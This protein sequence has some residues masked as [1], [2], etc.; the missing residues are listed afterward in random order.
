VTVIKSGYLQKRSQKSRND[1]KRRFFVLDSQV[2][3]A[4]WGG[5]ADHGAFARQ[6]AFRLRGG[7]ERAAL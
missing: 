1:Y 3:R 6:P 5:A 7:V 2:R 4:D